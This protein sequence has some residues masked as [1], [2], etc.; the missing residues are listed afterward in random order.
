MTTAEPARPLVVGAGWAGLAAAVELAAAGRRPLLLES[1]R[2]PGGR[3]AT[4][5]LAEGLRETGQHLLLGGCREVLRLQRR[6]GLDPA[7]LFERRPFRMRIADADHPLQLGLPRLPA[8]L[9]LAAALLT[10]R[11]LKWGERGAALALARA[12]RQPPPEPDETVA[13]FLHRHGQ[14]PALV[15]RL[16]GPLCLAALNT[17]ADHASARLFIGVLQET[18]R[19]RPDSDLLLQRADL[20]ACLPK[21]AEGFIERSGGQIVYGQRVTALHLEAGGI[22]GV[23]TGDGLWPARQ[24]VLATPAAVT[25][26]LFGPH[27]GLQETA[28]RIGRL[29]SSP[30]TTVYLRFPRPFPRGNGLIGCIGTMAEWLF[31]RDDLS[32]GL[33]AAVISGDGP[34]MTLSRAELGRHVA[35]ELADRFPEAGRPEPERVIRYRRGTFLAAP[36]VEENRPEAMTAVEGLWLAGDYTATGLPATLEGAVRS[37]VQ[38]AR[39]IQEHCPRV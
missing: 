8:P 31:P 17:P 27:P 18:F 32:P 12:L 28:A 20:G 21:A 13:D 19:R 24:V 30:L 38:C 1:A 25:R 37:G 36:D 34:H 15:R 5:D 26:R 4:L 23:A 14:P 11:G 22:T 10:A 29:Q 35:A 3:A 7:G 33:A 9:H 39:L 16:W 6:V 2:H